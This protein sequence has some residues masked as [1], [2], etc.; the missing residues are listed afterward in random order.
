MKVTTNE[1]GI[2]ILEDVVIGIDLKTKDGE[3]MTICM[4]DSGFEFRYQGEWYFAKE[5][6]V[7]PFKRS[8]RGNLL[9]DQRHE[10]EEDSVAPG[11]A[12]L[13]RMSKNNRHN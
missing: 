8:S 6:F 10:E 1:H 11:P 5:G 3:I 7:E 2:I 13:A 9:V 12:H 4:R